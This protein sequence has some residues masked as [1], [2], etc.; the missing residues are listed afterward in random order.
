MMRA[1]KLMLLFAVFALLA[2]ACGIFPL[3]TG[4]QTVTVGTEVNAPCAQIITGCATKHFATIV[5]IG[6][7]ALP[8][9]LP[10]GIACA[11][12]TLHTK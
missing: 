12:G 7:R 8:G 9:H 10:A 1:L 3:V 5:A 2:A 4:R 6:H 11:L